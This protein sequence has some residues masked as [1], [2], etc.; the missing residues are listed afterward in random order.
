MA[1]NGDGFLQTENEISATIFL[2][3]FL[4]GYT[5]LTASARS[6]FGKDA[7][8]PQKKGLHAD[9]KIKATFSTMKKY[10]PAVHKI[11]GVAFE[12]FLYAEK[13]KIDEMTVDQKGV[14]AGFSA[15]ARFPL[16]F[17]FSVSGSI[18]P[19][20]GTIFSSKV[21]AILF[22]HEIQRGIPAI[23]VFARRVYV[24]ASFSE[25]LECKTEREFFDIARIVEIFKSATN[26]D[27]T[28]KATLYLS[29]D[30]APNT[31]YFAQ[32]VSITASA[33]ASFLPKESGQK[34]WSVGVGA[35]ANF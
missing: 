1:F 27:W 8:N 28:P 10:S 33:F 6:F 17:P 22:S 30:F 9:S 35:S 12:P 29:L 3:R 5:A 14:N 13:I 11:A 7:K 2:T 23:S 26:E 18:Y 34:K 25:K 32:S 16:I 19:E 21:S 31:G 4:C 24:S 15:L 20:F